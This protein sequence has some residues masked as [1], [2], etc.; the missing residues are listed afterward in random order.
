M[1]NQI[2]LNALFLHYPFSG[3]GRYLYH[4]IQ[5]AA[6]SRD[7][8][9]LGSAA[10]PPDLALGD[11]VTR[12]LTTPFDGR[13]RSLAKVWFEQIALPRAARRNRARL[14]HVPYFAAPLRPLLPSCVTVHDLVPVI[15]PE[16]RRT[17]A[18]RLYSALVIRGLASVDRIVTDSV[19][20]AHDLT[21][22]LGISGARIRVIPL[23]V[24]PRFR[25]LETDAERAWASAVLA[26]QRLDGPY[27]LYVGGLDRRKN[28]DGLVRA[29]ARL[30]RERRVS[31]GLAIVGALR[32]GD[33]LFYDPRPDVERLG[34]SDSV[35]L[36]GQVGDDEV[37]A[38]QARADVF[39][40]PSL[41]EGFGLPPLEAMACGA[42]V[43]CSA[44]SSLPEVVG[45]AGLL[46]DPGSE[47]ALVGALGSL[48]DD[49][50][51][52][53]HLGRK[54]RE[55]ATGFTWEKTVASTVSVW[56]EVVTGH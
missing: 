52:R 34:I 28:V 49:V 24:D 54:G 33:A 44:A 36:L 30:R 5:G 8:I 38:L 2:A 26:R 17:A 25:P 27:F 16:Y 43:V 39:V 40:F 6:A 20:S 22:R 29:F 32:P 41:Y 47:D 11:L 50:E 48:V 53:R 45:D 35:R 21:T 56:D 15:R 19:A 3:T 13:S 9:L 14:A 51:L 4:L 31:Q 7:L 12:Q 42:P 18:Q 10:F 23:G 55:R 1:P 46:F 37:R